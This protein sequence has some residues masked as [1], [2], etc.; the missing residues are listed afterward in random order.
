[1]LRGNSKSDVSV[2]PHVYAEDMKSSEINWFRRHLT[3][4]H[5]GVYSRSS[6]AVYAGVQAAGGGVGHVRSEPGITGEGV[7][8]FSVDHRA[9][10]QAVSA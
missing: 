2:S 1:M 4:R 10:G 3:V 8:P 6:S 7:Q 9:M 5:G